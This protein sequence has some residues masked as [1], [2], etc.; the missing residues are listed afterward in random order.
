MKMRHTK[1]SEIQFYNNFVCLE[2][3]LFS[4]L[5]TL[6]FIKILWN[7][8]MVGAIKPGLAP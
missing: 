6:G 1:L 5:D 2:D 4:R 3:M 8:D 7:F